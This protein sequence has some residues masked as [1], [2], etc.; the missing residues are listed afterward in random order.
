VITNNCDDA[1]VAWLNCDEQYLE[2]A[3]AR[4]AGYFRQHPETEVLFGDALVVRPDGTLLCARRAVLPE[5]NHMLTSYL[6]VFSAALF[7]RA[8]AVREKNLFPDTEWKILG[9]VDLVDRMI[10]SGV[11]FGVIRRFLAAFTDSGRNISLT[12]D[13]VCHE[14]QTLAAR[15]SP[16]VRALKPLW[17][18]RH[19]VRKLLSGAYRHRMAEYSVFTD[20][21]S[22]R[23]NFSVRRAPVV[24][25]GR[26]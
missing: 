7:I 25:K 21:L 24:W 5:R 26:L 10:S 18:W 1:I 12:S 2:G 20:R 22:Q 16:S 14:Q 11:R 3:L 8:R 23:T 9:D 13:R 19:R 4:A 17:R 15:L 6:T